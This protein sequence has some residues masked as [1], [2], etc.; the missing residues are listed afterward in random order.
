MEE[1]TKLWKDEV[2]VIKE[3]VALGPTANAERKQLL[4]CDQKVNQSSF[5]RVHPGVVD[6]LCPGSMSGFNLSPVWRPVQ[7][8]CGCRSFVGVNNSPRL[9]HHSFGASTEV[10]K[11]GI[12]S[13]GHN[14]RPALDS[15]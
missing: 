14:S 3:R 8:L 13:P 5:N 7:A 1:E 15:R 4:A 10:A 9:D 11:S 12:L 2:E 6:S